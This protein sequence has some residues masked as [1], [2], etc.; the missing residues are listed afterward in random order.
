[1]YEATAKLIIVFGLSFAGKSTLANAIC[2]TFGYPQVDVDE[3]KDALFGPDVNDDDLS[4][5]KWNRIYA[6]T[7]DRITAH[8]RSGESVVDASRN[9]LLAERDHARI[10]SRRMMAEV[11]LVYVD[12][13]ET[14][15]R[16]RWAKN[17]DKKTRRDVSD[18]GFEEIIS[19]MEP[20]TAGEKSLV[21]HHDES[22]HR[23]LDRHSDDL[24]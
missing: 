16:E 15:V 10:L 1:M 21:F 6:E 4:G 7:D 14:L 5:E 18:R 22:I 9:F 17:R 3:T 24:S 20:P 19:F 13:P 11:V 23:W 12:A 8:L 2:A